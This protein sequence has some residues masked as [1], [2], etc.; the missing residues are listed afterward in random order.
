MINR[1]PAS[2]TWHALLAVVATAGIVF[3]GPV[4]RSESPAAIDFNAEVKPILSDNCFACHGPH[5]EARQGGFRLDVKESAFGETDSGARPIVPGDVDSSELVARI[6]SADEDYRMPPVESNKSLEPE[7]KALLRDWIEQGADWQQHWS[8]I[9]PRRPTLPEV[10][11][12]HWPRNEI[13]RFILAKL[14]REGLR[15]SKEA[16]KETLLRRVTFDLTGLPPTQTEL[17]AFLTD[18]S[19]DAYEKVVDRLLASPR[20]GEHMA[21]YWLDAARYGDTHGMHLDNYREMW[22]YRDWVVK[23]FNA[24]MPFDEFTTDQLAGDLLP[25]PTLEQM[26]ATGFNRCH[27][28]TNEGGSID[29]EVYVRNVVDRVTTVGTV[30]MGLTLECTRCH[31]H[32]YDPLTMEDFYSLSG[33]F[34]NLAATAMDGNKKDHAPVVQVPSPEQR[35][36]FAELDRQIAHLEAKLAAPWPEVDSQQQQWEQSLQESSSVK[37]QENNLLLGEWYSVGPFSETRRYLNGQQQGPEKKPID[38]KQQF[39]VETG[40]RI[41]WLRRTDWADGKVHKDLQGG[42]AANF[43]YR[44]ITSPQPQTITVH[45]GSDDGYKVYLNGTQLYHEDVARSVKPNQDELKLELKEGENQLLI[46][47]MNFGGE[48]GFC[49]QI[50]PQIETFPAEVILV[51]RMDPSERTPE[52][53]EQARNLFRYRIA[54]HPLLVELRQQLAAA[55]Q[56]RGNVDRGIPTTLVWREREDRRPT[57]LLVRGD[58]SQRGPELQR[59]T[60]GLLPAMSEDLPNNRLGLARWLLDPGHPLTARVTVNRFWQQVFGTG[61]VKTAEDFGSQGEPPSHPELLD[62]LAVEF[63]ESGWDVKSLMKQMVTSAAYQQSSKITPGLYHRDP[64]NRLLA[65]GPRFRLDGE[66]LRDQALAVSGLLVNRL[67]G[68][69]VKP[70]QPELWSSVGFTDSNTVRFVADKGHEKIHRR[71]LYTFIKRTS[72]PP[73]MSTFDAPS[74]ES[75]TVRRER[76]NTPMQALLL[77]ND[78]QYVEAAREL[79]AR[80]LRETS[81]DDASRAVYMFRLCVCR[82]P[83]SEEMNDLLAAVDAQRKTFADDPTAAAKLSNVTTMT[84][85]S[86]F[87]NG[88]LSV[89]TVLANTLLNLDEVVNKN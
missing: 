89:W 30:F 51:A 70:P 43:L 20:Y 73:Q 16:S 4:A 63:V 61:L 27:V 64:H 58:Y 80:T 21:R 2:L 75:C 78:P 29:E 49:F 17:D 50:D 45:F 66:M 55:R 6:F 88:E 56:Q 39:A 72:P 71:T 33:Y 22:P 25:N 84:E 54:E 62:W 11:N 13:D 87:D 5:E 28:T 76:T 74:R 31:N 26:V 18:Y 36:Q 77:M 14:Q 8:L 65:R 40:D 81:S 32:K 3:A 67:G 68:P 52:Q 69:G 59:R 85:A 37:E 35:K 42:Y 53:V 34:N 19:T 60:P 9:P 12:P 41:G 79:A 15:P 82:Q 57:Y 1:F 24:N 47:L 38:L 44:T 48:T 23:S 46:K 86:R 7:E 83:T 10:D